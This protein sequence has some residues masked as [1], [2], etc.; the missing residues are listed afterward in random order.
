MDDL[1]SA[2]SFCCPALISLSLLLFNPLHLAG[3]ARWERRLRAGGAAGFCFGFAALRVCGP[4]KKQSDKA[5]FLGSPAKSS[6]WPG[7]QAPLALGCP[8]RSG[9]RKGEKNMIE[10]IK[11]GQTNQELAKKVSSGSSQDVTGVAQRDGVSELVGG[12]KIPPLDT[13]Q[14]LALLHYLFKAADRPLR[15]QVA[16][17][18]YR[19]DHGHANAQD[20]FLACILPS[21]EKAARRKAEKLFIQPSDLQVELMYDGAV[22]AAIE[23]F[24]LNPALSPIPN[25][26]RRYVTR[27]LSR[28]MLRSYFMREE[29]SR[30]RPLGDVR[31][32]RTRK[33]FV[34]N[35]VERDI[36]ARE[37]LDQVT[38]YEN[39]RP[40]VLAM[41]QC[42]AAL[43]PDFALKEHAYTASG[44]PDKWKRD[45]D[46]RPIL[47]VDAIAESMEIPKRK[48]HRYLRE[49]RV[50]LRQAFNPDGRLFQVH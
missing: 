10:E 11:T 8:A 25:A 34:P 28:G 15:F 37:L 7:E 50:I 2:F 31:P 1:R 44:D 18:V 20:L 13:V 22:S 23:M 17:I 39:L 9:S 35:I 30:I 42:I 21:A 38:N 43:G 19:Y 47:D 49:A 41:L 45:R 16:E 29:N 36:I 3:T 14:M 46:R 33:T 26:F 6:P 12:K 27:G 40:P 5:K 32:V 4:P 48:V 24:Q